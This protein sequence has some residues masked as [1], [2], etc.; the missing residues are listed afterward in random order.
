MQDIIFIG[1]LRIPAVVG[2]YAWE[3]Q[4]KQDIIFDIEMSTDI[5]KA[6]LSDDIA[7]TLD[8]KAVTKRIIDFVGSSEFKLVET[9]CEKVAQILLSEFQ[10]G[11][12]RIKLNK[13]GAVRGTRDVG[14]II[15]RRRH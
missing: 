14:V 7:D 8:Y 11:W 2:I 13:H 12:V 9:L 5:A 4:I 6:A 10:I 1:G 3:R 15:E